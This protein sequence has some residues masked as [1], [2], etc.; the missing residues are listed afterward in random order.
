[1]SPSPPSL[2]S[3]PIGSALMR[4]TGPMTIG[5]LANM[6]FNLVDTFFISMLGE[7]ELAAMAYTYPLV[8]F[9]TGSSMGMSIGVSSVV[10]RALGAGKPEE[11]RRLTTHSLLLGIS[12]VLLLLAVGYPLLNPVLRAMGASEELI[13]LTRSYMIP[14]GLG[15]VF[16]V[17]PMLGNSV[18]RA[19][20]DTRVP[21]LVM[22][23]AGGLNA[24]LDP[25]LIFGW[26]PFPSLGIQGAALATVAA[27]ITVC[28][29][30]LVLLICK[31]KLLHLHS[32]KL[33]RMLASWREVLGVALPAIFTNQMIPVA[34][35]FLTAMITQQG[36]AAVAAWAVSIRLEPLMM[37]PFFALSTV[38]APFVGQNDG[39][40][41]EDR[42]REGLRFCGKVCM[43]GGMAVWLLG[44]ALSPWIAP[45]FSDEP[46]VQELI[47][48]HLL[49]VPFGYGA[50]AWK[51]Q[52]TSAFNAR[53]KPFYSSATFLGR[54]FLLI[55]PFAW[56]GEQLAG[57]TGLYVGISLGNIGSLGL[58]G[59]LW[60][61]MKRRERTLS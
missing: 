20:G 23:L 47:R 24:V 29:T 49:I 28:F 59:G 43:G 37:S 25:L 50:F 21:S 2:T 45:I 27:Y 4:M 60:I 61:L 13:P 51:L 57:L 22:I 48:L 39:A 10:S 42:I 16:I 55:L 35:G 11:V 54:F 5:L 17:T 1:M 36:K 3:G 40:G 32:V 53:K 34:N 18:I 19:T 8:F 7:S 52:F 9:V 38:M 41:Y 44:V 6:L 31:Y 14:W 33:T 56:A 12:V 46:E 58:A 26:G 15:I 30:M